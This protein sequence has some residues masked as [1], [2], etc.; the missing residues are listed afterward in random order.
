MTTYELDSAIR[1]GCLKVS[2]VRG[3]IW[4]STSTYRPFREYAEHY[5]AE[6]SKYQKDTLPYVQAKLLSNSLYGKTVESRRF[7]RKLITDENGNTTETDVWM[8]GSIFNPALGS[9]ITGRVRAELHDMEHAGEV[10]IDGTFYP[11]LHSSTDAIKTMRDPA[12]MPNIG[13]GL[14][15]WSVEVSGPCLLF[16]RPKIYVHQ[17]ADQVDPKTGD[18]KIKYAKHGFQGTL[19]ELFEAAEAISQGKDFEYMVQ[20]CWSVRQAMIRSK[21]PVAAL[22]FERVRCVL[23]PKKD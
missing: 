20:H 15:Q 21:N 4:K 12:E 9:W 17:S 5:W 10:T 3:W 16:D 2:R 13:S 22:N 1:H 14:G 19:A 6:K 11:T 23:H 18:K 8:A 7:S